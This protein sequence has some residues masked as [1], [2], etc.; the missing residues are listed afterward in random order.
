M[1]ARTGSTSIYTSTCIVW[2]I[3][4]ST[5]E[6]RDWKIKLGFGS[7]MFRT[8]NVLLGAIFGRLSRESRPGRFK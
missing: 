7:C 3:G 4:T 6:G 8:S 5:V 1:E 2:G